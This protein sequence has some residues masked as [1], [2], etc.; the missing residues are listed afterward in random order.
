MGALCV[1]LCAPH[2]AEKSPHE[3]L[4]SSMHTVSVDVSLCVN[5]YFHECHVTVCAVRINL[6]VCQWAETCT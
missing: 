4:P 5:K 3:F 1:H 6:E 2:I